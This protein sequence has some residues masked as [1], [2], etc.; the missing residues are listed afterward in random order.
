[1]ALNQSEQRALLLARVGLLAGFS[2]MFLFCVM[3]IV[4]TVLLIFTGGDPKAYSDLFVPTQWLVLTLEVGAGAMLALGFWAFGMHHDTIRNQAQNMSIG[5]AIWA[6]INLVWRL[7]LVWTPQE[8]V[9]PISVRLTDG[10]YGIF[11]PHFEFFRSNYMGFFISSILVFVLMTLLVRLIRNYRV[12]ENFQTVNLK[13]F[14]LYGILTMVGAVLMG[15]GWLAFSPQMSGTVGGSVLLVIYLVAWVL[16]FL[17]LPFVGM[18]VFVPAFRIHQSAV[19]TLKFIL[20]RKSEREKAES[21]PE[22]GVARG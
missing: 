4:Y 2:L 12:Y 13:W 8:E 22:A 6:G 9:N 14:N 18:W 20:R 17:V 19:E 10:D 15:V 16:L 5:F 11:V 7:R 1:M 21:T 3:V